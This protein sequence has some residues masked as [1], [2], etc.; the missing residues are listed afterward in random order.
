MRDRST[1][2]R[3]HLRAVTRDARKTTVFART[4]QFDAGA[5]LQFDI[6]DARI[7]A[8]EYALGGLVADIVGGLQALAK[9]RRVLVE[10]VEARIEAE[11]DNALTHLGVVG[12]QGAPHL[13]NVRVHVYAKSLEEEARVREIWEEMLRRSPLVSTLRRSVNLEL[14]LNVTF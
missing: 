11:L 8:L 13:E 9:R 3:W 4:H 12:E 2:F 14:R 10:Q 7:S 1:T 6:E 5:P